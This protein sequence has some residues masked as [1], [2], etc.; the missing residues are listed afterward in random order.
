[1]RVV[2]FWRV[3]GILCIGLLLAGCAT[4]VKNYSL[5]PI[6]QTVASQSQVQQAI[7]AAGKVSGWKMR[8]GG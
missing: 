7:I 6:P 1:M 2:L 3:L 4:Q 5:Q 8:G